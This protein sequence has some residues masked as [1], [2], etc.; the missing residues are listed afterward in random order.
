MIN[1]NTI[2]TADDIITLSD[3]VNIYPVGLSG[4]IITLV[5]FLIGNPIG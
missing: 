3:Y 2:A 4:A 5:L 1:N